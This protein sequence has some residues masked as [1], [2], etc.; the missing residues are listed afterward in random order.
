[1]SNLSTG[2]KCVDI[3]L[4][5]VAMV[6]CSYGPPL[7]RDYFRTQII[8]TQAKGETQQLEKPAFRNSPSKEGMCRRDK[9]ENNLFIHTES[10]FPGHL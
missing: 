5:T 7:M 6:T 2:L 10:I 1:M 4:L 8:S 9:M 3:L